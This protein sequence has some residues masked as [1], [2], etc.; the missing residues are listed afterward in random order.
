MQQWLQASFTFSRNTPNTP[1]IVE[2]VHQMASDEMLCAYDTTRRSVSCPQQAEVAPESLTRFTPRSQRWY[3]GALFIWSTV[4]TRMSITSVPPLLAS[5]QVRLYTQ[6]GWETLW[7]GISQVWEFCQQTSTKT[8]TAALELKNLKWIYFSDLIQD[9]QLCVYTCPSSSVIRFSMCAGLKEHEGTVTRKNP[10]PVNTLS[11]CVCVR[12]GFTH[13]THLHSWFK[14]FLPQIPF[15]RC[16][17]KCH[18]S[19]SI[20]FVAAQLIMPVF[21]DGGLVSPRQQLNF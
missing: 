1:N 12:A 15:W 6:T 16:F 18:F 17:L 9:V 10:Q 8:D 20:T 2:H 11:V 7:K 14:H 21:A 3:V 19:W 13:F 5:V 4:S